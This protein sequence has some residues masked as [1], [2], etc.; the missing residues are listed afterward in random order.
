MAGKL[1]PVIEITVTGNH[2]KIVQSSTV[3]T[4]VTEFDLGV[5]FDEDT[6]DGRKMKV[7]YRGG[8]KA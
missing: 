1:K 5:E 6:P 8:A 4:I 3:K 7:T 2:W